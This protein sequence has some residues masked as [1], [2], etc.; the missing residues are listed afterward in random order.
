MK[1]RVSTDRHQC[2]SPERVCEKKPRNKTERW[3]QPAHRSNI[4][5]FI[6]RKMQNEKRM[7]INNHLYFIFVHSSCSSNSE[8]KDFCHQNVTKR[9]RKRDESNRMNSAVKRR[10]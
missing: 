5:T 1:H 7:K 8:D 6:I 10:K 4:N 3:T 9:E 2:C